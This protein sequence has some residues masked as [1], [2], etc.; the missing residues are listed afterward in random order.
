MKNKIGI[1]L[2]ATV[3]S[4]ALVE[5]A[6]CQPPTKDSTELSVTTASETSSVLTATNESVYNYE[7]L[8]PAEK[9]VQAIEVLK[10][11]GVKVDSFATYEEA[12]SKGLYLTQ[13]TPESGG[14]WKPW[15]GWGLSLLLFIL[16]AVNLYLQKRG[17]QKAAS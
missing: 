8:T 3:F 13:N 15:L 9:Y 4:L 6:S 7:T 5:T 2:L 1:L 14:G 12:V 16:G 17:K 10:E 11:S